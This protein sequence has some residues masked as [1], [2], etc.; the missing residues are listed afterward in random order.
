[1]SKRKKRTQYGIEA[2]R[3][4]VHSITDEILGGHVLAIDPSCISYSS[5]PGWALYKKGKLHSSGV[6]NTISP[7][8]SLE[9]RLQLLGKYCR[10]KFKEP[11]VLAIEH[12][13]LGTRTSMT[14]TIRATGAIIG[15][16]EC[17]HVISVSPLSWQSAALKHLNLE[18]NNDYEKYQHYK[19]KHK[20][21]EADAI[22]LGRF[23][24]DL[25]KEE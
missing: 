16:F 18:G 24:V 17:E 4:K 19:A 1:M 3:K 25:A 11:D 6:I 5:F 23:I 13:Q 21:D 10:E 22:W 8:Y 15:N 20:S 2:V 9:K 14:S 7:S 12:I